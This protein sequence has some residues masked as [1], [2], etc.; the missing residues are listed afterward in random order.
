MLSLA[1]CSKQ[2]THVSG[3]AG[4]LHCTHKALCCG[5]IPCSLVSCNPHT[6]PSGHARAASE[7]DLTKRS[8]CSH[9]RSLAL[10]ADRAGHGGPGGDAQIRE[11][12]H[13]HH[14]VGQARSI[15]QAGSLTLNAPLHALLAAADS[16]P[17]QSQLSKQLKGKQLQGTQH[18]SQG[19]CRLTQAASLSACGLCRQAAVM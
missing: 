6:S 2:H 1:S 19:Q 5:W 3:A 14:V 7:I 13:G 10:I 18:L 8:S 16:T 17:V 11:A 12:V 9:L 15:L 4:K